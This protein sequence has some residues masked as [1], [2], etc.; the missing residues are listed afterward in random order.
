MTEPAAL[1]GLRLAER[2]RAG[3]AARG[4][5]RVRLAQDTGLSMAYLARIEAASA[6]PS[7][8]VIARL[9]QALGLAAHDLIS[10]A[11]PV[12]AA[13][14]RTPVPDR[15]ALVGLRGAGKSTL[16]ARL[17][18][19]LKRPFV[20]L[21]R[22][23][24]RAGGLS[25]PEILDLVG[26]P[27][28]RAL[29]RQCLQDVVHA[30]PQVVL[31]TG[32]GLVGD[33]DVYARLRDSFATV[34]LRAAPQTHFDRVRRQQDRRIASS[35]LREAAMRNITRL[36]AERERAYAQARWHL[37]TEGR[38]PTRSLAELMTLLQAGTP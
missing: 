25:L 14:M 36:L 30:H 10:P 9:A 19:R 7:L 22:E 16:G 35:A 1:L 31:A 18:A 33:P 5:T 11:A 32:G 28:L 37:D 4:L 21:N 17:A 23:V 15:I 29:E 12:L 8:D 2:V 3:R 27:G 13:A 38:T 24:V 26:E 20:E 6:N 34:W